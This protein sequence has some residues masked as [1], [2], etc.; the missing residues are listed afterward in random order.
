MYTLKLG[1]KPQLEVQL[2]LCA[3]AQ[4]ADMEALRQPTR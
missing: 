4:Q 3:A 1:L 2:C